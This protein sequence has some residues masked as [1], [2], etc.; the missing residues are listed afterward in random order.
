VVTNELKH[1]TIVPTEQGPRLCKFLTFWNSNYTSFLAISN[2]DNLLQVKID[3][4]TDS[5]R[6]S[7]K[8]RASRTSNAE[9][10]DESM[11]FEFERDS[12]KRAAAVSKVAILKKAYN[13]N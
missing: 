2:I 8:R 10:K 6:Q 11:E 13:A 4:S 7:K 1:P 3:T 9:L 5:V 12:L